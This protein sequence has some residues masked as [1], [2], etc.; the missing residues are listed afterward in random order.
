[1]AKK[2]AAPPVPPAPDR[3][4]TEE[5]LCHVDPVTGLWAPALKEH[6]PELQKPAAEGTVE[7]T[8]NA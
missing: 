2:D 8:D 6:W 4:W 7:V 3:P 5:E 1:M